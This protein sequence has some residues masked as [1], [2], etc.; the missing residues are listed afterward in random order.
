MKEELVEEMVCIEGEK[1]EEGIRKEGQE[2]EE[3]ILC[4]MGEQ[5]G[6]DGGDGDNR[7]GGGV[8]GNGKKKDEKQEKRINLRATLGV[9]SERMINSIFDDII[10]NFVQEEL[11]KVETERKTSIICDLAVE[12]VI[13]TIFNE[14]YYDCIDEEVEC[15]DLEEQIEQ[16]REKRIAL[17]AEYTVQ[18]VIEEII[19]DQLEDAQARQRVSMKLFQEH[20]ISQIEMPLVTPALVIAQ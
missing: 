6:G 14:L 4:E 10:K 12:C 17:M 8:H 1:A 15:C 2:I 13:C 9:N 5:Q 7:N 18:E 16:Q 19:D 20:S 11:E 3:E